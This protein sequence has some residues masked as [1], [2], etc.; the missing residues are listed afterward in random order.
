M[1]VWSDLTA[2]SSHG[3]TGPVNTAQ[4]TY[5]AGNQEIVAEP[6]SPGKLTKDILFSDLFSPE[7]HGQKNPE[8]EA[9]IIVLGLQEYYRGLKP[10]SR[11]LR[12]R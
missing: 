3:S 10:G 1:Q 4:V 12:L 5:N 2:S 11:T 9:D 7:V 6:A 8:R